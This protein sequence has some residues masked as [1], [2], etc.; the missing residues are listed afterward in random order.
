MFC[1]VNF[2]CG[3]QKKFQGIHLMLQDYINHVYTLVVTK[4][5]VLW[6]A[7]R[8]DFEFWDELCLYNTKK[9]DLSN[10]ILIIIDILNTVRNCQ[11]KDK[12]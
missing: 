6:E 2:L 8:S 3:S 5:V 9:T 10:T 7:Q 4:L 11:V 1:S 12:F